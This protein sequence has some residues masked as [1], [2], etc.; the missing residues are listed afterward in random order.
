MR[1]QKG[2]ERFL[3]VNSIFNSFLRDIQTTRNPL[4]ASPLCLDTS[5]ADS[6]CCRR[7][8]MVWA[9]IPAAQAIIGFHCVPQCAAVYLPVTWST[10]L[11]DWCAAAL[12]V[13][14]PRNNWNVYTDSRMHGYWSMSQPD[15]F[16]RSI[17]SKTVE[18]IHFLPLG[19][20]RPS[21]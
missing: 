20:I 12:H 3:D 19:V 11:Y 6:L 4:E 13:L 15:S 17:F 1:K 8:V 2:F 5:V 9:L 10:A 16:S 21:G 14:M 7:T 18:L